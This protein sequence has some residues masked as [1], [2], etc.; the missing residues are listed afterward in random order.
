MICGL[1]LVWRE[2]CSEIFI[3]LSIRYQYQALRACSPLAQGRGRAKAHKKP[4]QI[5]LSTDLH[6]FLF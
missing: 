3:D 4:V 2:F 1:R 5:C 6:R